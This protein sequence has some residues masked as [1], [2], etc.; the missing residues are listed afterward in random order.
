MSPTLPAAA[1]QTA[2]LVGPIYCSELTGSLR[3]GDLVANELVLGGLDLCS[4]GLTNRYDSAAF[5]TTVPLYYFQGQFDPIVSAA[6]SMYHH[7]SHPSSRS[8]YVAIGN[9]GHEPFLRS[10]TAVGCAEPIWTAT[11]SG[12]PL[13]PLLDACGLPYALIESDKLRAPAAIKS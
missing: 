8:A 13:G 10:L 12:A 6:Q 9:A 7:L 5:P 4:S 11:A 2:P 1:V 3:V